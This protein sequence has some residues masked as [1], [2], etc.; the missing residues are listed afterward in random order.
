VF[1]RFGS[2]TRNVEEIGYTTG[3]SLRYFASIMK[4]G[5]MPA[6]EEKPLPPE[7]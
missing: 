5:A 4:V 7:T 1:H 3:R 6:D 2:E